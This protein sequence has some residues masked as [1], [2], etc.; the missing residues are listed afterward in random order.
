[1]KKILLSIFCIAILCALSGCSGSEE[2][3]SKA[4]TI[5]TEI[6]GTVYITIVYDDVE[7]IIQR[8]EYFKDIGVTTIHNYRWYNNGWGAVCSGVDIVVV[9]ENGDIIE[10]R[11]GSSD[12]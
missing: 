6:N 1:M 11:G 3:V 9:D 5:E 12:G 7:R 10:Y 2:S 8:T 4:N